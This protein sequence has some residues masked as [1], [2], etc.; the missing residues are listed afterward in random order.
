MYGGSGQDT[1]VFDLTTLPFIPTYDYL[2]TQYGPEGVSGFNHFNPF[3]ELSETD[4]IFDFEAGVDRIEIRNSWIGYEVFVSGNSIYI[5]DPYDNS[6]ALFHIQLVGGTPD[7]QDIV[8][9]YG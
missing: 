5:S 6:Q 1:F 2:Y 9:Y 8:Y 4:T 7:P 3:S